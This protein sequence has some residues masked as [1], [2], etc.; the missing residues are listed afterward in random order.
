VQAHHNF[1]R[2]EVLIFRESVKVAPWHL[3]TISN[4]I[5]LTTPLFS[6]G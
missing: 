2:V 4:I 5:R 1:A 3:G 6:L